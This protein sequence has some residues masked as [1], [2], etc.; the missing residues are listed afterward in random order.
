M[1]GLLV[2]VL[3]DAEARY[4]IEVVGHECQQEGAE[5]HGPALLFS[6]VNLRNPGL[7]R[8]LVADF[9]AVEA[10]HM[11]LGSW[12]MDQ[13]LSHGEAIRGR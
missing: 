2:H 1:S 10:L 13:L 6:L 9:A 4:Q 11:A 8:S 5:R 12:L 3:I 7:T